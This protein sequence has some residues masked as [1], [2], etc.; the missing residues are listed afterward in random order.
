[1]KAMLVLQEGPGAGRSYPLDPDRQPVLSVGRSGDCG[2]VLDDHRASRHHA[3]FSWN[4]RQWE[5]VDKGSTNGTYVNGMQVHRPYDL[6]VG[7]RVTIGETTFVLREPGARAAAAAQP[8]RAQPQPAAVARQ[9][10]A[11]T[12]VNPAFWLIAA[13]VA[14]A[15]VCLATGAFLPWLQV[16]G[17]LSQELGPLMQSATGFISSIFG[18]DS[19]FH[20]TQDVGGLEG[21]GKLT[22][23]VAVVSA[24]ALAVDVF[25]ARKTVVPGIVYLL[26]GLIATAAMASDLMSFYRLYQQVESWSLLFGIQLGQV[27][28][29]LDKFIEMKVTPQI[30]LPLTVAGLVLLLVGGVGRLVLALVDRRRRS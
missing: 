5:V 4:G 29:F 8:A 18:S 10:P 26:T 27:V 30:G 14:A 23:A 25:V 22:L 28:Q 6:R 11:A 12:R 19:L 21:Y 7:D 15:V 16:T 17:S 9:E 1:M 13:I 24:I 20:V 2:I 3:D